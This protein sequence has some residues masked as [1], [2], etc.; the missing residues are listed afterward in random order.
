M[1][2]IDADECGFMR[3]GVSSSTQAS[4]STASSSTAGSV[5]GVSSSSSEGMAPAIMTAAPLVGVAMAVGQ[6]FLAA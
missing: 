1:L 2:G 6:L 4:A 3:L 5:A